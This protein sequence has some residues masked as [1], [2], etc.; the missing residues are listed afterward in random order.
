MAVSRVEDI[1]VGARPRAAERV[2]SALL[3]CLR[4]LLIPGEATSVCA[5]PGMA[6]PQANV[7]RER[8]TGQQ[9][10]RFGGC[11]P[12]EAHLASRHGQ[13]QQPHVIGHTRRPGA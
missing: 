2:T 7:R 11:P 6:E 9:I 3:L 12:R 13:H 8:A 5:R 1:R 4:V 10:T